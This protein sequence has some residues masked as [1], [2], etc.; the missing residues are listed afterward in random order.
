MREIRDS[1]SVSSVTAKPDLNRWRFSGGKDGYVILH[2]ALPG[3]CEENGFRG[4]TAWKQ[5]GGVEAPAATPAAQQA[6]TPWM[7]AA[8]LPPSPGLLSSFPAPWASSQAAC[9]CGLPCRSIADRVL[10][11]TDMQC[12]QFWR[13]GAQD[14]GAADSELVMVSFPCALA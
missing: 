2:E 7:G 14:P 5:R 4:R 3:C 8:C 12:S 6:Y 9:L 1:V 11:T 10:Q 13:L